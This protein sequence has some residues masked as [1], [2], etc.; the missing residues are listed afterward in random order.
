[1][2]YFE[3]RWRELVGDRERKPRRDSRAVMVA[4]AAQVQHRKTEESQK[5]AVRRLER[6]WNAQ[7]R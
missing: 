5:S 1:M 2:T 3:E 4:F 7:G 6:F